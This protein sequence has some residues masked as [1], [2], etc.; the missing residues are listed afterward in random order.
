[1]TVP[2][3]LLMLE[4]NP[5]DAKLVQYELRRCG[6]ELDVCLTDSEEE[7]LARL[8][9]DLDLV[10][11]DFNLPQFDALRALELLHQSGVDVPF[12][13]VS[14]TIG[15]EA[16]AECIKRGATD[17][18]LKDRLSRLGQAVKLALDQRRLRREKQKAEEEIS[19]FALIVDASNDAI[20]GQTVEGVINTWN[21][22]AAKIY[23]YSDQEIIG[24]PFS[25]LVPP[26]R[27]G[28]L[29]EIHAKVGEGECV[30]NLQ[31]IHL[32]REGRPIQVSLTVSP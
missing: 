1:M 29:T 16:A 19:R 18:L 31:S 15:E 32:T 13:I 30:E 4:D 23:G 28:E 21:R 12:I 9:P 5:S 8:N 26:E 24:E 22:G 10:L 14:G 25:R 6:F 11:C 3:R 7:Y 17:Y 20:I 2:L 27:T